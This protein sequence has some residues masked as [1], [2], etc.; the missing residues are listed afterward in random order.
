M[1]LRS[2][3]D[4][5]VAT[6]GGLLAIPALRAVVGGPVGLAGY[7]G[8]FLGVFAVAF[9]GARSARDLE[10]SIAGWRS[11]LALVP[12]VAAFGWF[13]SRAVDA[14]VV[15]WA[16][17]VGAVAVLPAVG[18]LLFAR[19]VRLRARTER[20]RELA[21]FEARSPPSTRRGVVVAYA[22]LFGGVLFVGGAL[23]FLSGVESVGTLAPALGGGAA[24]IAGIDGEREVRIT[25]EGVRIGRVFREWDGLSGYAVTDE[26]LV[27]RR[28]GWRRSL[29]FDRDDV[30]DLEDVERAL[31]RYLP[32]E[33]A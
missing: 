21:R 22:V 13:V 3:L 12:P 29:R 28:P 20:V 33:G 11:L 6:Y 1:N 24:G 26:A 31:G 17:A 32:R 7:A 2:L 27:L 9:A 18:A 16:Y 30:E 14:D 15:E 19:E 4:W 8:T 25:D 5:S 23:V 10:D